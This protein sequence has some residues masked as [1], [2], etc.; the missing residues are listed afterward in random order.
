MATMLDMNQNLRQHVWSHPAPAPLLSPPQWTGCESASQRS[1]MSESLWAWWKRRRASDNIF[2]L[3][4]H[5][6]H[7]FPLW[8][9][10]L[11][12]FLK[13]PPQKKTIDIV[14]YHLHTVI[15]LL[16]IFLHIFL[17]LFGVSSQWKEWNV[18]PHVFVCVCAVGNVRRHRCSLWR[19]RTRPLT[20]SGRQFSW[21]HIGDPIR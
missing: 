1:V 3:R 18:S 21:L 15:T 17:T 11:F 9:T 14:S 16:L 12:V 13:E 8:M 7:L 19:C 4:K 2:S 10:S 20:L 6:S 5:F